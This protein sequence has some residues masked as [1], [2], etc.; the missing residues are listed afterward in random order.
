MDDIWVI[1]NS[2]FLQPIQEGEMSLEPV[3]SQM[4]K[5]RKIIAGFNWVFPS[6]GVVEIHERSMIS[7]QVIVLKIS[8]FMCKTRNYYIGSGF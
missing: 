3:Y 4:Q 2:K 6:L 7:L 8:P 5:W 1:V